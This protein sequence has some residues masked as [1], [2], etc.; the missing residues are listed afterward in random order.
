MILERALPLS[1]IN[2]LLTDEREKKRL[3]DLIDRLDTGRLSWEEFHERVEDPLSAARLNSSVLDRSLLHLAVLDNRMEVIRVLSSDPFLKQKKSVYGLTPIELAQFL[4][5]KEALYLLEPYAEKHSHPNLPVPDSFERLSYPIFESREHLE[6]VLA[7]TDKAKRNDQIPAEKIW[8]GIY[9]DK[10]IQK[11]IHA[12]VSIRYID[13]SV[14]YGVFADKKIAPCAFVG[15][16]TGLIQERNRKQLKGKSYCLRYTLWEGKKQFTIDAEHQG[17]F[18]RFINHSANPN[19]GLQSVYWR[20]LPRMIF[21]AL[22]EIKEGSQ[23][24]FDYGAFFW[25]ELDQTPQDFSNDH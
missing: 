10:E 15:E 18:T 23:L 24:T 25:K 8:M 3:Q 14:G 11:G 20:G 19:L 16:Y 9:F 1:S 13:A 2:A 12:P 4:H 22:Q 17:N 5:R 6:D 21:V 7:W